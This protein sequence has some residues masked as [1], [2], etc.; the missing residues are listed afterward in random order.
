MHVISDSDMEA[1]SGVLHHSVGQSLI[2]KP[3]SRHCM[4]LVVV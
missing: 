4:E 3:T 2:A 1:G